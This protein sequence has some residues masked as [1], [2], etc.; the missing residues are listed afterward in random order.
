MKNKTFNPCGVLNR[1]ETFRG[2][3]FVPSE[4]CVVFM[5][6]AYRGF[7]YVSFLRQEGVYTGIR[8]CIKRK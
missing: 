4:R 1:Y 7:G 5:R 2:G 3:R 6:A 8:V